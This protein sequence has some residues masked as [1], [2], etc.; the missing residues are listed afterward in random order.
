MLL[1]LLHR[2][3][4]TYACQTGILLMIAN[5]LPFPIHVTTTSQYM[6]RN[7]IVCHWCSSLKAFTF[8]FTKV[9][10]SC[11]SQSCSTVAVFMHDIIMQLFDANS[12]LCPLVNGFEY[13]NWW[14]VMKIW[15]FKMQQSLRMHVDQWYTQ[16][17]ATS[18]FYS[19]L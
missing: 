18:T 8:F 16:L 3:N 17:T 7:F 15:C 6:F 10:V 14:S 4:L 11:S 2:H 13:E 5:V 1:W 9:Y 19:L 12:S